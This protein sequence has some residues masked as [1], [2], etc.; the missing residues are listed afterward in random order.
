[1]DTFTV[2]IRYDWTTITTCYVFTFYLMTYSVMLFPFPAKESEGYV[3]FGG[4]T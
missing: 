3:L 4:L 2:T 1:M